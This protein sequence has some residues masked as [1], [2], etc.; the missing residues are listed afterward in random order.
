MIRRFLNRSAAGAMAGMTIVELST[1]VAY[2]RSTTGPLAR[3]AAL[4]A[5]TSPYGDQH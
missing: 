3:N 2:V 5:R 1:H 4:L